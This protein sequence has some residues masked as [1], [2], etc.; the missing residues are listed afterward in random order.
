MPNN[1]QL[2]VPFVLALGDISDSQRP[3][4]HHRPMRAPTATGTASGVYRKPAAML[5]LF[6]SA[7]G[8]W[9]DAVPGPTFQQPGRRRRRGG[10]G[11]TFT[12]RWADACPRRRRVGPPAGAP[13]PLAPELT[14]GRTSRPSPIWL[15][16]VGDPDWES[17][18]GRGIVGA[19][20]TQY[21]TRPGGRAVQ[22]IY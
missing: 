11:G 4:T 18:L 5:R 1:D 17:C 3:I 9:L 2:P 22:Q 8:P 13:P 20:A 19:T 7:R 12:G 6:V 14:P 21:D 15:S 10:G 16:P